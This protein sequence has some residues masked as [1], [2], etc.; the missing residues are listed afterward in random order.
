MFRSK[1]YLHNL[2][3]CDNIYCLV[4]P[5]IDKIVYKH[6][7][8]NNTSELHNNYVAAYTYTHTLK[9]SL[10][11]R[12]FMCEESVFKCIH[13]SSCTCVSQTIFQENLVIEIIVYTV[14]LS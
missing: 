11:P 9:V 13:F 5:Y 2:E 1:F 4:T 3:M 12:T 6:I 7:H 8:V 10:V 14:A